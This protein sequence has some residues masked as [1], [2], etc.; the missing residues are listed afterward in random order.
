M[1]APIRTS[2]T[3]GR[4]RSQLQKATTGKYQRSLLTGWPRAGFMSKPDF[5]KS[6]IETWGAVTARRLRTFEI[7]IEIDRPD[8]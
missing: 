3:L 5:K 2:L 6:E 7:D 8:A 4:S 1:R